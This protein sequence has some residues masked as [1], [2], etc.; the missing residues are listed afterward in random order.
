MVSEKSVAIVVLAAGRSVRMGETGHKLLATF[1]GVPMVRRA[2]SAALACQSQTVI[3]VTGYRD[4]DI[5]D[6]LSGLAAHIVRNDAFLSGMAS[7]IITGVKTA[8][9]GEPDGIMVML[10]DMPGLTQAH[11]TALITEFHRAEGQNIIRAT[12]GGIAGHPVVFPC[13]LY[14]G[15]LELEG[16]EGAKGL[17]GR[18]DIPVIDVE[19]GA[20]AL[21]DVDT[22]DEVLGAGGIIRS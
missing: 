6:A 14:A 11:L 4:A 3:V 16:D 7:S 22:P 2:V 15:L 9:R 20:A 5:R 17:I 18:A 1:D 8:Q 10:A 19:I 12:G 13:S 21:V